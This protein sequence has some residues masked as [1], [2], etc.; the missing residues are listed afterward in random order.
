MFTS[1][2]LQNQGFSNFICLL[3]SFICLRVSQRAAACL[4]FYLV[5]LEFLSH[6]KQNLKSLKVLVQTSF[7]GAALISSCADADLLCAV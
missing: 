4:L 3:S 5:A 6:L 7:R 1:L 2:Q